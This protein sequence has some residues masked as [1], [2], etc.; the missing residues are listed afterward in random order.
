MYNDYFEPFKGGLLSFVYLPIRILRIQGRM[1]EDLSIQ[2]SSLANMLK[3][4]V[5]QK[6]TKDSVEV[7]DQKGRKK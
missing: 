6:A 5:Y 7:I 4:V 1:G 3:D 2:V